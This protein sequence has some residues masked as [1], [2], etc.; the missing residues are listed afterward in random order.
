MVKQMNRNITIYQNNTSKNKYLFCNEKKIFLK[1]I[2]SKTFLLEESKKNTNKSISLTK[3]NTII[4][5]KNSKILLF[6]SVKK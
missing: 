3:R 4:I 1:R 2:Y 6:S 5:N